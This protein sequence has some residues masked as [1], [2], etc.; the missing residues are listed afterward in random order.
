MIQSKTLNEVKHLI[1]K[2]KNISKAI[3]LLH[4]YL[5][6]NERFSQLERVE[7]I[8]KEYDLMKEYMLKGYVD[9]QR[10]QLYSSLL[11]RLYVIA[12]NASI[13]VFK[14]KNLTPVTKEPSLGEDIFTF[15]EIEKTLTQF[16]QDVTMLSLEL[17]S[18]KETKQKQIYSDHYN[19][20]SRLFNAI[21]VSHQWSESFALSFQSL[22]LS[23]TIETSDVQQIVSAITLGAM[24]VFDI[25]KFKTLVTLYLN[26]ED[27]EVK[28]R[29]FVGFAFTLPSVED[30]LYPEVK[31]IVDEVI[32]KKGAKELYELQLQVFYCKNT[33]ADNEELQKNI[34]PNIMGNEHFS[35]NSS[36]IIDLEK[37]NLKDILGQH[38]SEQDIEKLEASIDKMKDMQKAGADIYFGGFARMKSFS[39]F[40]RLSNWFTPFSFYHPEVASLVDKIGESKFIKELMNNGPFCNSDK[41]SFALSLSQVITSLP[42][43]MKEMFENSGMLPDNMIVGDLNSPS[44]IRRTYLQDLYRFFRLSTFK[45][46]FFNPFNYSRTEKQSFFFVNSLLLDTNLNAFAPELVRFLMKKKMYNEI[47][48]ILSAYENGTDRGL[49]HLAALY[50]L[51][52]GSYI[53]AKVYYEMLYTE[54]TNDLKALQGLAQSELYLEHH[55]K[56]IEYYSILLQHAPEKFSYQFNKAIALLNEGELNDG[57]NILFKL[58]LEKADNLDVKRAIAWGYLLQKRAEDS[59]KMYRSFFE[60]NNQMVSDYLNMSYALWANSEVEEAVKMFKQYIESLKLEKEEARIKLQKDF[61][62]DRIFFKIYLYSDAE[63]NIMLDLIFEESAN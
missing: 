20:L 45:N 39:F 3:A 59:I 1:I 19:Y 37:D 7:E 52:K 58:D 22:L 9:Q 55:K 44:Y 5:S 11:Q 23:P 40:Y 38:S 30:E 46:V 31:E 47:P 60:S 14:D 15:E 61:A 63:C 28:Q 26:A 48:D 33:D 10:N 21:V 6:K 57:M 27:E 25:N 24:Q 56:A 43:N 8:K 18:N 34:L 36:D 41:Y 62:N 49:K 51:Q 16:V 4:Q 29:A 32:A 35:L 53:S 2:D 54:D 17:D 42:A 12:M 50:Y 13:D